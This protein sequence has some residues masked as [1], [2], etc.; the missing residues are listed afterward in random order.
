MTKDDMRYEFASIDWV[1]DL[2]RRY[3][4]LLKGK[5]VDFECVYALEYTDPPAHL[6]RNDGR[7][8]IGYTLLARHGNVEVIDGALV[9]V[10]DMVFTA[11]YYPLG[12]TYHMPVEEF[13]KW[14][15][16]NEARLKAE[17][18]FSYYGERNDLPQKFGTI[19]PNNIYQDLYNVV[20]APPPK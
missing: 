19:F 16:E 17:N 12:V 20:T 7:S 5:K 8:T 11:R 10:A 13:K 18:N 14:W 4:E 9:A 15:A 1:Q 2:G 3:K 6:L